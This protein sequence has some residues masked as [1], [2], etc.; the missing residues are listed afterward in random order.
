MMPAYH[1]GTL[2][3]EARR[4]LSEA[5]GET[6]QS[7]APRD[8]FL[9]SR[10][11]SKG[12]L[13][14]KETVS[15]DTKVL[16][17][18]LDH[19]QQSLGLP[20]GQHLMMRVRDSATGEAVIRSYTPISHRTRAGF[21]D[22]LVKV[23]YDSRERKGGKMSQAL[24]A[25]PLGQAVDFKGP[26]G[27][28][29]YL[30]RGECTVGAQVRRVRTLVMICGG[31]GITPIYQVYRAIMEDRE[32][33]TKVVVLN[34]NRLFEDILCREELDRLAT[35]NEDRCKILYTLTQGTDE[36]KGLRGRING[37]LLQEHAPCE[38]DSMV[39][40]CGPE[41]M[42]KACH[43]ALQKQGWQAEDLFSF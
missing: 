16:T 2:T 20:I 30:G 41:A 43:E 21:V 22:V 27:K 9:N 35:G 5:A 10:S 11:W 14:A 8:V 37:P 4:A 3:K 40:I 38:A 1:I 18:A 25:L 26:V 29:E 13:H 12:T 28:F 34:G 32:D 23:Y 31:S 6:G 24:D 19:E 17:F 15:W 36:W 42:E 33:P 7:G 39:L